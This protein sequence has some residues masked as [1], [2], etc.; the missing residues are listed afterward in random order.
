MPRVTPTL[1]LGLPAPDDPKAARF[2][3]VADAVV[4]QLLVRGPDELRYADIARS[5]DVSRAWLYKYFGPDKDALLDFVVQ[6]FGAAFGGLDAARDTDDVDAWREAMAQGVL[7]GLDDVAAAPWLMRIYG[8]YRLTQ[9]RLG[10][11]LRALEDRMV[12][13]GADDLPPAL[14]RDRGRARHFVRSF[15]GARLGV[16]TIWADEA[17]RADLDAAQVVEDLMGIVDAFVARVG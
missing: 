14:R 9:G 17:S 1:E 6:L 5:A 10:A 3:A 15:T 13:K 12:D 7:R 4:R 11:Q 16:Y 8:R 2:H